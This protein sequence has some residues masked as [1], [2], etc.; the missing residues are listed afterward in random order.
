MTARL[1]RARLSM[2]AGNSPRTTYL[3]TTNMGANMTKRISNAEIMEKLEALTTEINALKANKATTE[4]APSRR[5]NDR[6]ERE[7]LNEEEAQQ[8]FLGAQ[9]VPYKGPKLANAAKRAG[10][11]RMQVDLTSGD[12]RK[13][14][15]RFR[16]LIRAYRAGGVVP[17]TG[18]HVKA[19]F[20][21]THGIFNGRYLVIGTPSAFKWLIG[22]VEEW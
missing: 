16:D 7:E 2:S 21:L 10:E 1:D 20:T 8:R 18:E 6:E 22:E 11:P 17:F 13:M 3:A 14:P 12:G 19:H 15:K 4:R 9:P 5:G